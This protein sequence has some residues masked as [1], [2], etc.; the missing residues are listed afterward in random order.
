MNNWRKFQMIIIKFAPFFQ[1]HKTATAN[2]HVD[3]DILWWRDSRFALFWQL[4]ACI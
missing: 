2:E 3:A 4:L 1:C